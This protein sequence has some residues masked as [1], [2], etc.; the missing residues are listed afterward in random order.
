MNL[1][2]QKLGNIVFFYYN[3]SYVLYPTSFVVYTQNH[4]EDKEKNHYYI[5][6]I[7]FV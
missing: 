1:I 5:P 2:P 6:H 4:K 3:L 7:L